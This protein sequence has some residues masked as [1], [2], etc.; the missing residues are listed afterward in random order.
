LKPGT[1][2]SVAGCN[3]RQQAHEAEGLSTGRLLT[4]RL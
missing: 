2:L 3:Q 1:F 4:G